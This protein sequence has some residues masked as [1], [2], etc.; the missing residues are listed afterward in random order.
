MGNFFGFH[1]AIV[2]TF[3]C[4]TLVTDGKDCI[5]IESSGYVVICSG[6]VVIDFNT[7]GCVR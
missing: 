5:A 3:E 1:V 4:G 2:C 6:Y 7:G